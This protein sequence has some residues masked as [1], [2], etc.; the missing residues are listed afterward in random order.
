MNA[1][2]NDPCPCGSG[3]QYKNCC[4]TPVLSALLVGVSTTDPVTFTG[5]VILFAFVALVACLV[6]AKQATR[7]SPMVPLRS[8]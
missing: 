7:V 3:E 6:P 2:R 1:G 5:T 8:E 4:L